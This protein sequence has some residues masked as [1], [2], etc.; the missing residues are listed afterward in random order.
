MVNRQRMRG[1]KRTYECATDSWSSERI[2]LITE[3]EPFQEGGMRYAFKARELDP[4]GSE[5][6]CV[7]KCFKADVVGED[8]DVS[9]LIEAEAMTQMV[10]EDYAQQFNRLAASKGMSQHTIAFV[11]VSVVRVQNEEDGTEETYSIEPY[12]CAT[13]FA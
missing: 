12:G 7:L 2:E 4:D 5:M 13:E 1:E 9:Q 8:E 10:A 6:E 11:P 3:C